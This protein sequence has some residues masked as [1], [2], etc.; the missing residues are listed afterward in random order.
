[1]NYTN[2]KGGVP[3]VKNERKTFSITSK[4]RQQTP[5]QE[6]RSNNNRK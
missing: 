1:M 5:Q 6:V 4:D 2:P 3:S